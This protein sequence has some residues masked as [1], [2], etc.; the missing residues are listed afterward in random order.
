VTK[1]GSR[2]AAVKYLLGL[3]VSRWLSASAYFGGAHLAV[4][5][6]VGAN[7]SK[8]CRTA[9]AAAFPRAGIRR[10]AKCR[11]SVKLN[12]QL[13]LGAFKA[14]SKM[15]LSDIIRAVRSYRAFKLH[16]QGGPLK[17]I[18]RATRAAAR[19]AQFD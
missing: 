17:A 8:R 4:S 15:Q 10:G 5:S 9:L 12:S 6:F 2:P 13:T 11:P 3:F 19:P 14:I 1:P 16:S 7:V 18:G